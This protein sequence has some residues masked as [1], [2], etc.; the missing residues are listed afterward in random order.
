MEGLNFELLS[1]LKTLP[2]TC[3]IHP[4][5]HM[6]QMKHKAKGDEG[7]EKT[8]FCPKCVAERIANHHNDVFLRGVWRGYR[9]N[10][11]GVLR[12]DSIFD[13]TE[14]LGESFNTYR[15]DH[16][17]EA[18]RNLNQA[19]QLAGRYL[20]RSYK[21][22]TILTGKPGTG[23]THLAM[24][25]LRAIND[26]IKPNAM[27]LFLSVNEVVRL[28]K[29]S[30]NNKQSPYTEARITRLAGLASVLVLDDLGSEASF[31]STNTEASDWVQQLLFGILNKRSGRT[32]VTTNLNSAQLARIYNPKLLS[33]MYRGVERNHSIIKFTESTTDK[34]L[35][36]F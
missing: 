32:I 22:N 20:D 15:A 26:N 16:G 27:C 18:E 33:R 2:E 25:M 6:V 7:E 31:K 13:D 1:R 9:R 5:Q 23:K 28:V 29:D 36:M 10:F 21:A 14:I 8:P 11:Y 30:F 4:D 12:N 34:R 24:G 35:E 19:R 3:P 17:S